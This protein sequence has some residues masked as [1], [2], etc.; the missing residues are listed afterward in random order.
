MCRKVEKFR[1]KFE[2]EAQLKVKAPQPGKKNGV[3]AAPIWLEKIS[4]VMDYC[5]YLTVHNGSKKVTFINWCC[6]KI[7]FVFLN[8]ECHG[9]WRAKDL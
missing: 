3:L 9:N 8:N 1:L 6:R 5:C 4:D 2:S 7:S